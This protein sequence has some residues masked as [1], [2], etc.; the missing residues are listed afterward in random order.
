MTHPLRSWAR[1]ALAATLLSLGLGSALA[2]VGFQT[3]KWTLP[4]PDGQAG[5]VPGMVWYPS[6]AASQTVRFG[7]FELHGASGAAPTPGRH[8]LVLISHGTGGNALG[9]AW[10]AEKLAAEGYLVV[11]LRHAGDNHQDRSSIAREDYFVQR[12]R[13]VSLVLDAVLADPRWAA[14]VDARR[15]A[16]VGHSA[17]GYTALALAGGQPDRAGVQRHCSSEGAGLRDDAAMCRLGGFTLERPAPAPLR[18]AAELP[19]TRDPRIRAV[20][21][22][23]PLGQPLNAASL[24]AVTVP[25]MIEHSIRDEVL[26]TAFHGSALCQAMPR[27]RCQR[28]TD[29]GHF[30]PFQAG[31][32]PLGGPGLDPAFDPAGFDRVAWQAAAWPRWRDFLA[33]SLGHDG[34]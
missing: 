32:G 11:A 21:A 25:V 3:L 15:I 5:E 20:L 19:Q 22:L 31:T 27:A 2:Q 33:L 12:P 16:V 6:A 24:G 8:P 34:S 10:L 29:A 23:S 26:A 14:L 30:A 7:P 17:G 4:Q 13:Q 18:P 28:H 9:H 1:R